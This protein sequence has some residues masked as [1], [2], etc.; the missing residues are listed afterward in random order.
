MAKCWWSSQNHHPAADLNSAGPF[1]PPGRNTTSLQH[2][3]M[4]SESVVRRGSI[5]SHCQRT[6]HREHVDRCGIDTWRILLVFMP[7]PA[8]PLGDLRCVSP[9]ITWQAHM[10]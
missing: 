10:L 6:L 8:I 2:R 4:H 3:A 1:H 5:V 7:M 9:H